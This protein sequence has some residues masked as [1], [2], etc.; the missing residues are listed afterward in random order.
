MLTPAIQ[1][2]DTC[3]SGRLLWLFLHVL[4][5]IDVSLRRLAVHVLFLSV[6][7]DLACGILRARLGRI[8]NRSGVVA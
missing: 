8:L 4:V 5:A 6:P 3:R 2:F 7:R 1:A